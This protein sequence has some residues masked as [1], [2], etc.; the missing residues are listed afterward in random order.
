ME[1]HELDNDLVERFGVQGRWRFAMRRICEWADMDALHHVNNVRYVEWCQ[2]ARIRHYKAV[3]GAWPGAEQ[4]D[5]VVKHLEFTFEESL[6]MGDRVLV[7]ARTSNVGNTSFA[8]DYAIW[9]DGLIGTGRTVCVTIATPGNIKVPVPDW[10][11]EAIRV[12]ENQQSEKR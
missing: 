3:T 10:L 4:L 11:R 1:R 5:F 8:Q 6:V 12:Y 9:K 2:E 7:T